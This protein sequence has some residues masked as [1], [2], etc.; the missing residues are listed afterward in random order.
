MNRGEHRRAQRALGQKRSKDKRGRRAPIRD[1][2]SPA[3]V[4]RVPALE[5]RLAKEKRDQERRN[6]KKKATVSATGV[7]S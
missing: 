7:V 4:I 6:P 1:S 5:M 3:L 2:I